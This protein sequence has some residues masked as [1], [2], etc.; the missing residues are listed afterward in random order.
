LNRLYFH[1]NQIKKLDSNIFANL[2]NLKWLDFYNNQITE[3]DSNIFANLVNLEWLVFSNNQITELD[4]NIFANLVNLEQLSFSNNQIEKLDSNIF[5]NL[6][7][8]EVLRFSNNQIKELHPNIFD[9]LVYLVKLYI[10]NNQ[11]KELHSNIFANLVKL[12]WLSFDNNQIEKLDSNIF[13]N[14]VKLEYLEFQNNQIKELHP[15]IFEKLE[16]LERLAF[17]NNQIKELDSNIFAS[18]KKLKVLHFNNNHIKMLDQCLFSNLINLKSIH[19][20]GNNDKLQFFASSF[21]KLKSLSQLTAFDRFTI[22]YPSFQPGASKITSQSDLIFK[23]AVKIFENSNSEIGIKNNFLFSLKLNSKSDQNDFQKLFEWTNIPSEISCIIGL[24][25]A[26]K[27]SLLKCIDNSINSNKNLEKRNF[28]C[29]YYSSAQSST[30]SDVDASYFESECEKAIKNYPSIADFCK[31]IYDFMNDFSL[32]KYLDFLL[33]SGH[34]HQELNE[35]LDDLTGPKNKF[36]YRFDETMCNQRKYTQKALF[37]SLKQ[38]IRN[39]DRPG[40]AKGSIYK[41]YYTEI[42]KNGIEYFLEFPNKNENFKLSSGENLILL[43]LLWK[44]HAQ[45][46]KEKYEQNNDP[47]TLK[48]RILL[49][50]EPDAHMHPSLIEDFLSLLSSGDLLYLRMQVIITTHSPITV[51]LMAKKTKNL[52]LMSKSKSK[53]S[54][55]NIY[56]IDSIKNKHQAIAL[57]TEDLV[58][59]KEPTRI[60]FVEANDDKLYYEFLQSFLMKKGYFQSQNNNEFRLEFVAHGKHRVDNPEIEDSCRS[61]VEGL[62]SKCVNEKIKGG[63]IDSIFGIVDNDNKHSEPK[64]NIFYGERYALEN[65]I[66]DPINMFLYFQSKNQLND[67]PPEIKNMNLFDLNDLKSSKDNIQRIVNYFAEKLEQESK[68]AVNNRKITSPVKSDNFILTQG[69]GSNPKYNI[70]IDVSSLIDYKSIHKTVED[71]ER[72]LVEKFSQTQTKANSKHA[73]M[74]TLKEKDFLVKFCFDLQSKQYYEILYPRFLINLRGKNLVECYSSILP[75]LLPISEMI[76]FISQLAQDHSYDRFIPVELM[77]VLSKIKYPTFDKVTPKEFSIT[78]KNLDILIEY[79]ETVKD[80]LKISQ[81]IDLNEY[82]NTFENIRSYLDFRHL[83]NS[84]LDK[85]EIK[86]SISNTI[87]NLNSPEEILKS[88]QNELADKFNVLNEFKLKQES[89]SSNNEVTD[90]IESNEDARR[91][92]FQLLYFVDSKLA[93]NQKNAWINKLLCKLKEGSDSLPNIKEIEIFLDEIKNVCDDDN[94]NADEKIACLS[95]M[96]TE[97]ENSLDLPDDGGISIF[98]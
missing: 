41:A 40:D 38:D 98:D 80:D 13:A 84:T 58:S 76:K 82:Q 95:E 73:K 54:N 42:V 47:I 57:L 44:F 52:Y 8:L 65:Y 91:F 64:Q 70:S 20:H 61:M 51:L 77:E 93:K 24:N 69:N 37:Q 2:V 86:K 36:N 35:F 89:E 29:K 50:D 87:K 34:D 26:G 10:S 18:L 63:L 19:F 78:N 39:E 25:G 33:L 97:E 46:L 83:N 12:E 7:K 74:D 90:V 17:S 16:N 27:T 92:L 3:L 9:T 5:A 32:I 21:C 68:K 75:D 15:N 96:V 66:F 72:E 62:V 55:E 30:D 85:N 71:I 11:I 23:F 88:I 31:I 94:M 67:F 53:N 79:L 60:V 49:L 81:N 22:L 56:K 1:N 48:T 59:V 4:S 43:I 6:V 14:L 28:I 45:K